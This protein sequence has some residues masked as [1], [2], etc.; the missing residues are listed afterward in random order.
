MHHIVYRFL[1]ENTIIHDLQ[2]GFRE[3]FSTA[4]PST[5]NFTE[6]SR[7]ALDEGYIECVIFA[8]LQKALIQLIMKFFKQNSIIMVFVVF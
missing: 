6:N 4:M 3:N 5:A 8:D 7:Q 2:F 1:T